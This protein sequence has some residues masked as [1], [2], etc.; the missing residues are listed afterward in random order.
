MIAVIIPAHNEAECMAACLASVFLAAS[1]PELH[2]AVE[3]IVAVDRCT[4]ATAVLALALGAHVID[5]PVPGGVGI[6]R[7]AAASKAI[8]LGADWLAVTDA[9]SRVPADWLVEQRRAD[10]DV[11]CGVV[12]VEDWLDY[13]DEVRC[14]FEQTQ[15]TGQ[16][17]GRI[18]G[19]NLG[20]STALYQQCGGFSALTCSE[21]VALVHA[22]QAI[23]ASIAWSPC[24]VVWTSARRQARAIGG[25][26]D[27]LKQLEASTCVPA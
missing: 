12:Q 11:F 21:D 26:S 13:S 22:L 23:N 5:V 16:G 10:A 15:A 2:E 8:A 3:V 20:V 1:H 24:S 18:H 27:F 25:F 4:D 17:H 14:R 7:A 6:A 9:D 19:A